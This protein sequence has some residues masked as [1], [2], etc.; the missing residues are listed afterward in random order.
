[1]CYTTCRKHPRYKAI[2]RPRVDCVACWKEKEKDV[3]TIGGSQVRQ[4]PTA[5][6]DKGTRGEVYHSFR[7]DNDYR[8]QCRTCGRRE[9]D[10]PDEGDA[11]ALVG[12]SPRPQVPPGRVGIR[13]HLPDL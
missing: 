11:G 2:L 1:M 12:A 3:K 4:V 8:G 10:H 9:E 13:L 5:S 7:E 6:K